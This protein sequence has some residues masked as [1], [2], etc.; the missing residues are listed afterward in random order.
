[1]RLRKLTV[2]ALAGALGLLAA[3]PAFAQRKPDKLSVTVGQSLTHIVPSGVKT[4]SI[5]NAEIADVV[6]A[7]PSEILL[8]GKEVG[9][10]TLVVWDHQDYSTIFDVVV[11]GQWSEHKIELQVQLAEVDHSTAKEY[12]VDYLFQYNG[13]EDDFTGGLYP[14]AVSTPSIPLAAFDGQ[15]VEGMSGAFR[16]TR[17]PSKDLTTMIHALASEGAIRLLAEPKMVAASGTKASFLSGG[18][19]PVP[20]ASSGATGGS[21]VTIEW[22]EFGVKVEFLPTIIDEDLINLQVAPEVSSLDFSNGIDLSGF[23]IPA[24]RSRKAVTTVELRADETLVIGGLIME[25]ESIVE[26]RIPLLGDI[27]LLGYLFRSKETQ[28]SINELML[29]VSPKIVRS[30]PAGTQVDLPTDRPVVPRLKDH[31]SLEEAGGEG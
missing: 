6:V 7:G 27:P 1:M 23:R 10:T 16:W 24:L 4:V 19:I 29:V 12:G 13:S 20:V 5:A 3:S 18:E 30:L 11:R 15:A 17:A 14:G 2:I 21:T 9:M 25:Q 8:N 31:D 26:S 28:K 22:K